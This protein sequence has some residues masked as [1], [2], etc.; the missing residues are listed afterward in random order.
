MA[1]FRL[2]KSVAN[3]PRLPLRPRDERGFAVL[4]GLNA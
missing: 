3:E 1:A 4:I 2:G